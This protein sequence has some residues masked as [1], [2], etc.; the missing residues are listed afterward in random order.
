MKSKSAHLYPV[1]LLFLLPVSYIFS[2]EDV[3]FGYDAAGNRASSHVI[4]MH[5]VNA[6][7][8][9]S[10][11]YDAFPG[12]TASIYPNPTTGII[13]VELNGLEEG[14]SADISLYNRAN[15]KLLESKIVR[16][17]TV[18][19]IENQPAGIYLMVIVSGGKKSEWKIIKR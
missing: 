9:D 4:M 18:I 3:E 12:L 16:D 2:Q 19:N 13:N 8:A 17:F 15:Q 5:A 1:M 10:V 7:L 11:Y 14:Q 6:E